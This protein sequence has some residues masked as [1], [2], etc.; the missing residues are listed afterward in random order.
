MMILNQNN[1][2]A[3][4]GQRPPL[5]HQL[6]GQQGT[7]SIH[8]Q[9]NTSGLGKTISQVYMPG[10]VGSQLIGTFTDK[11][12]DKLGM[13]ITTA[14]PALG[15]VLYAIVDFVNW[16]IE[17]VGRYMTAMVEGVVTYLPTEAADAVFQYVNDNKVSLAIEVFKDTLYARLKRITPYPASPTKSIQEGRDGALVLLMG[18]ILEKLD[19]ASNADR[20]ANLIYKKATE[21]G[22]TEWQAGAAIGYGVAVGLTQKGF[23]KNFSF[24]VPFTDTAVKLNM[25]DKAETLMQSVPGELK[26]WLTLLDKNTPSDLSDTKKVTSWIEEKF[27]ARSGVSRKDEGSALPLLAAALALIAFNK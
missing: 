27:K 10:A 1:A 17:P 24:Q 9:G 20:F 8:Y 5:S 25:G 22:A 11:L 3:F 21:A 19:V 6:T 13:A 4:Y 18:F 26:K 23:P 2:G 7:Q 14:F 15:T 16:S 12:A